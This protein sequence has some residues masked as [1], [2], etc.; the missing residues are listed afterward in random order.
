MNK[1]IQKALLVGAVLFSITVNCNNLPSASTISNETSLKLLE[2]L[3]NVEL[4]NQNIALMLPSTTMQNKDKIQAFLVEIRDKVETF[5]NSMYDHIVRHD[6]GLSSEKVVELIKFN[7]SITRS[8]KQALDSKFSKLEV[9]PEDEKLSLEKL[10]KQIEEN[11]KQLEHINKNIEYIGLSN[12]KIWYR[13]F[14]EKDKYKVL[15]VSERSAIYAMT[16]LALLYFLSSK[17]IKNWQ[18]SLEFEDSKLKE[19]MSIIP[20]G[21]L[22]LALKTKNI[23]GDPAHHNLLDKSFEP[24]PDEITGIF[25]KLQQTLY[26]YNV[27]T[28]ALN[29]PIVGGALSIAA[30]WLVKE[31]EEIPKWIKRKILQAKAKLRGG[32]ITERSNIKSGSY[33]LPKETLDDV[34]GV[35]HVKQTCLRLVEQ[36][37]NPQPFEDANKR[38]R[39][40]IFTGAPRTGKS[41]TAKAICGEI[42]KR[43]KSSKFKYIT[44]FSSDFLDLSFEQIVKIAEDYSPCILCIEEIDTLNLQKS[45][46]QPSMKLLSEFLTWMS[47]PL[48]NSKSKDVI[49][50]G[51]TNDPHKLDKALLQPGRFD[52]IV[53][54]ERPSIEHRRLHLEKQLKKRSILISDEMKEAVAIQT[55]DKT[56][57]DIDNIIGSVIEKSKELSM[58][59]RDEFFENALD[60]D[61]RKIACHQRNYSKEQEEAVSAYHAGKTLMTHLISPERVI[62][63]T[64]TLP[65]KRKIEEN[66]E[67]KNYFEWGGTFS[68]SRIDDFKLGAEKEILNE[69]KVLLAG[70]EA[71]KIL[72][73]SYHYDHQSTDRQ[74]AMDNYNKILLRGQEYRLFPNEHKDFV[75]TESRKK[76]DELSF[77]VRTLL[78][79]NKEKL[80]ELRDAL[81]E[82]EILNQTEIYE[83]LDR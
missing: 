21:I 18:G 32:K 2:Q 49:V 50:I 77:E 81:V 4:K 3:R 29:K 68:Y 35:D 76:L 1:L 14:F 54:F 47:G 25:T 79:Q 22:T 64:T 19:I 30:G 63:K 27:N 23:I 40:V 55:E 72:T 51:I 7:T 67:T 48:E 52:V 39:G 78:E 10:E 11:N 34:I 56:Y 69:C 44:V 26:N 60:F 15:K 31:R 43:M 66:R 6:G 28:S 20:K 53:P 71:Q 75:V 83:V 33:E 62:A 58:P 42:N 24:N 65:V 74:K 61:I 80:V 38:I 5:Q 16:T 36:C 37:A 46:H 45:N 82:K 57:T 73:G 13:E 9:L 41:F 8:L 12:L 59:I 17:T 70:A